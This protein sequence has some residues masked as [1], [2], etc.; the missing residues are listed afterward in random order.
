MHQST[1]APTQPCRCHQQE[2]SLWKDKNRCLI[3]TLKIH[4]HVHQQARWQNS[5]PTSPR[6]TPVQSGHLLSIRTWGAS[7]PTPM[8]RRHLLPFSPSAWPESPHPSTL[9]PWL[10]RQPELFHECVAP[11]KIYS[12]NSFN[13]HLLKNLFTQPPALL[14]KT[15]H[16]H[17]S[18]NPPF[19]DYPPPTPPLLLSRYLNF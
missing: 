11:P 2:T 7:Q 10:I 16:S 18:P 9:S 6:M 1:L 12:S 4:T 5:G 15:F 13:S 8:T 3:E 19:S 14:P 17:L